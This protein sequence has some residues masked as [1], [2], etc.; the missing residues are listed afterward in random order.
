MTRSVEDCV[1]F[2]RDCGREHVLPA[3]PAKPHALALM[4]EME[5]RGSIASQ[6]CGD[7]RLGLDY[8]FGPARG[9][10]FGVL[11]CLDG[12][13][14]ERVLKA[15]SGQYNGVWEVPGW[16]RPI[17]DPA[18]FQ[19]TIRDDEPRIKALTA[20]IAA[21]SPDDP[22]RRD[23]LAERRALS[24]SLMERIFDLYRPAN[25]RGQRRAL[26]DVFLGR[27]M[28]T[29][30]G[31]CCAPKLL[32]HAA[33]HGLVPLALAE[34]YVGQENRSGT[35]THG[36]FFAPCAEKCRPILGFMLCGIDELRSGRILP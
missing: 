8:L 16:V 34:F 26:R 18:Q 14:N 13:G 9:Q 32:H 1:G 20:R 33:L 3:A 2:C 21:L 19:S 30:T 27:A 10:M 25:F 6:P 4:A 23:F 12:R 36:R 5:T 35:R 11:V 22:L 7:P 24:A 31:E 29:G 17:V 28:P 15:F